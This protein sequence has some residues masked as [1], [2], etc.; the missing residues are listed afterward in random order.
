MKG[1]S[2][3]SGVLKDAAILAGWIAAFVFVAALCWFLTQPVRSRFLQNAVNQTL[4]RSGDARR[5]G[6][7]EKIRFSGLGFWYTMTKIAPAAEVS[8]GYFAEGS[9]VFV[10]VFTSEG[11]FFPCAAVLS[12]EGKVEEF[13]PIGK[14]GERMLRRVSRAALDIYARRV[15]GE[16]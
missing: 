10:F 13:I 3:D 6:P 12:P 9:K 7:A 4:E 5:L 8:N 14:R 15:E 1:A 16:S 11:T 2:K